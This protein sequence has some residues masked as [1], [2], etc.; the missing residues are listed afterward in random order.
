[1][2]DFAGEA[3]DKPEHDSADM[4]KEISRTILLKN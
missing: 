4:R 3:R 1:M 2:P